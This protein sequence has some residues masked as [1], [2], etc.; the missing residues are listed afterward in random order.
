V[1]GISAA[2]ACGSPSSGRPAADLYAEYCARCH[3]E[4]G[5]GEPRQ[6]QLDPNLDLRKSVVVAR[7]ARGLIYQR[8]TRGYGSMPAFGHKLERGDVEALVDFVLRFRES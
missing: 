1:F 4:D 7:G 6:L 8:I 3:G 2:L 5:R